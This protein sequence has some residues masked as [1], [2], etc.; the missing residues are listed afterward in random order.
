MSVHSTVERQP[1]PVSK[2]RSSVFAG[3]LLAST[4]LYALPQDSA[5]IA[6]SQEC[7]EYARAAAEL[8]QPVSRKPRFELQYNE[9][10]AGRKLANEYGEDAPKMC[11]QQH[12]SAAAAKSDKAGK[13]KFVRT[14]IKKSAANFL[15]GVGEFLWVTGVIMLLVTFVSSWYKPK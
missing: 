11:L 4:A 9:A 2:M 14:P 15:K 6:N 5:K 3:M 10:I 8:A 7:R 12:E 1:K 13:K